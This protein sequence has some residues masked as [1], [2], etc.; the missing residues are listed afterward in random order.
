MKKF[1]EGR[2]SLRREP[3]MWW[4]GWLDEKTV[5]IENLTENSPYP[6]LLHWAGCKTKTSFHVR[7]HDAIV[8]HFQSLYYSRIPR[9]KWEANRYAWRRLADAAFALKQ[10]WL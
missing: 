3:F 8:R 10:K 1:Q 2:I 4:A 5:K 6:V 7:R 9:T